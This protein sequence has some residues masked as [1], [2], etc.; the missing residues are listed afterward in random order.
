MDF[1]ETFR[2]I[3]VGWVYL[4][5]KI[6]GKEPTHDAGA[7]RTAYYERA[8]GRQRPLHGKEYTDTNFVKYKERI[9]HPIKIDI[10]REV[11]IMVEGPR[12]WL[13]LGRYGRY[14]WN[15][16]ERER[17]ERSIGLEEQIDQELERRG[18]LRS[19]S[20]LTAQ[21]DVYTDG[22]HK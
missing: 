4:V 2:E 18:Y 19:K 15:R 10:D 16:T 17:S 12:Q 21:L 6:R 5:D 1:R 22:H 8:F 7:K 20:L 13:G 11:E 3:W 14:A 9:P